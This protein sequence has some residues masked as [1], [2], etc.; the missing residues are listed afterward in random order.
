MGKQVPDPLPLTE[1]YYNIPY[2][3]QP[4]TPA[5]LH[6]L[7]LLLHT[8][9]RSAR[10]V[11]IDL[12]FESQG[13]ADWASSESVPDVDA[14]A[15]LRL[16]QRNTFVPTQLSMQPVAQPHFATPAIVAEQDGDFSVRAWWQQ[17]T[18]FAEPRI[19]LSCRFWSR[20][21]AVTPRSL[22]LAS[23]YTAIVN[24]LLSDFADLPA[25]AGFEYRFDADG[26]GLNLD[27]SGYSGGDQLLRFVTQ[28]AQ[29]IQLRAPSQGGPSAQRFATIKNEL[30]ETYS[31]ARFRP[32]YALAAHMASEVLERPNFHWSELARTLALLQPHDVY[33]FQD[34]FFA[35][36]ALECLVHGNALPSDVQTLVGAITRNIAFLTTTI[37]FSGT[38]RYVKLVLNLLPGLSA[39]F[40]CT[41]LMGVHLEAGRVA[42]LSRHYALTTVVP[43]PVGKIRHL[44]RPELSSL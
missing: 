6:E 34:M 28:V 41:R 13:S 17:A 32:P 44:A 25:A 11:V 7:N 19:K 8:V 38:N 10:C 42:Q 16:P 4:I 20:Q 31:N 36:T 35:D 21:L 5:V 37:A 39:S 33:A 14:G 40:V 18:L 15:Q 2:S 23:L 30:A 24:D 12:C 22:V 3:I 27:F 1:P 9:R 26:A 29:N 43:N